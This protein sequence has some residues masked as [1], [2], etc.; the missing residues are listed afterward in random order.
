MTKDEIIDKWEE[1]TT[2]ELG[3][4][5]QELRRQETILIDTID[6]FSF[7]LRNRKDLKENI[8]IAEFRDKYEKILNKYNVKIASFNMCIYSDED[9]SLNLRLQ[10]QLN[11]TSPSTLLKN[12]A[13]AFASDFLGRIISIETMNLEPSPY[14]EL[15]VRGKRKL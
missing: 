15:L 3:M 14:C 4:R 1:L 9:F 8:V 6:Q 12:I 5:L 11:M 10:G 2:P 13:D 7:V